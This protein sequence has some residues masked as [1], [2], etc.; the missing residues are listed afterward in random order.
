MAG[1]WGVDMDDQRFEVL[2]DVLRLMESNDGSVKDVIIKIIDRFDR[3]LDERQKSAIIKS[4]VE[5]EKRR[6]GGKERLEKM[7]Y[8]ESLR[9]F[10]D[11][12]AFADF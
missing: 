11:M 2:A 9:S 6:D 12:H 3:L 10:I 5:Y 7:K 1:V 4:F 8:D